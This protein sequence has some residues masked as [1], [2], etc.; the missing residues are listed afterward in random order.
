MNKIV[1]ILFSVCFSIV[2]FGATFTVTNTNDAGA[3]SL[4]QAILDANGSAGRD[5]IG[6]NFIGN[7]SIS[8]ISPLPSITESLFIDGFS[9]SNYQSN[10][11]TISYSGSSSS[12]YFVSCNGNTVRGLSFNGA[13]KAI[14]LILVNDSKIYQNKFT[15]NTN[16]VSIDAPCISNEIYANTFQNIT[17]SGVYI[18]AN[19]TKNLV[20][21]NKFTQNSNALQIVGGSIENIFQNNTIDNS[22]DHAVIISSGANKTRIQN[23]TIN[24]SIK[25]G[26]DIG[27][28][29]TNTAIL[30]NKISIAAT[31]VNIS[32]DCNGTYITGS[33]FDKCV[34]GVNLQNAKKDTLSQNT[35]LSNNKAIVLSNIDSSI[36]LNNLFD[37]NV[38][39]V[40]LQLVNNSTLTNN[41]FTN[42]DSTCILNTG[43]YTCNN[44][45]IN[46][47]Y[48]GLNSSST[49]FGNKS[50]GIRCSDASFKNSQIINNVICGNNGYGIYLEKNS[51]D[52]IIQKNKIGIDGAG[53]IHANKTGIYLKNVSAISIGDYDPQ[54]QNQI[55]G[56]TEYG[57]VMGTNAFARI[58]DNIISNNGIKGILNT[59]KKTPHIRSIK[60]TSTGYELIIQTQQSE[61]VVDLYQ[62]NQSGQ[63]TLTRINVPVVNS[64]PFKNVWKATL[65]LSTS[66]ANLA[67]ISSISTTSSEIGNYIDALVVTS[68]T[69][70]GEGTL[71]NA[72][73]YCNLLPDTNRVTFNIQG[74]GKHYLTRPLTS[75]SVDKNF[76]YLQGPII[77]DASMQ[78]GEVVVSPLSAGQM[79]GNLQ[80]FTSSNYY[81]EFNSLTL[82]D[83]SNSSVISNG[84][85]TKIRNMKFLNNY[86]VFSNSGKTTIENTY[87]EGNHFINNGVVDSLIVKNSVFKNSLETN[88]IQLSSSAYK[89]FENCLFDGNKTALSNL[90][91]TVVINSTFKNN[92]IGLTTSTNNLLIKN[93]FENNSIAGIQVINNLN[94][95]SQ[96]V[97]V[98]GNNPID[99]RLLSGAPGNTSKAAPTNLAVTPGYL[100][101]GKA[102]ANDS[103]E[104]FVSTPSLAQTATKYLGHTQADASGNWKFTII[105]IDASKTNGIVTT[106]TDAA[107]NTSQL[108]AQILVGPCTKIVTNTND[109]GAGSLRACIECAN[110][111]AGSDTIKFAISGA[112]PYRIKPITDL[113]PLGVAAD[114]VLLSGKT[115]ALS[116]AGSGSQEIIL[117]GSAPPFGTRLY[118][119]RAEVRDITITACRINIFNTKLMRCSLDSSSVTIGSP[120]N[121]FRIGILD[122]CTLYRN[123]GVNFNTDGGVGI[124]AKVTNSYIYNS[125]Y[126]FEGAFVGDSIIIENN[127]IGKDK[128][129]NILPVQAGIGVAVT[130]YSRIKNNII[131]TDATYRPAVKFQV[132]KCAEIINNTITRVGSQPSI[133]SLI[134]VNSAD[135]LYIRGNTI[136]NSYLNGI[137]VWV[138]GKTWIEN[139][140][141]TNCRVDGIGSN[142]GNNDS[143]YVRSN[144]TY[145]NGRNGIYIYATKKVSLTNNITGINGATPAPNGRSGIFIYATNI[146]SVSNNSIENNKTGLTLSAVHALSGKKAIV[147]QNSILKSDTAVF[148]TNGSGDLVIK[149]N[150]MDN[151]TAYGIY[152]MNGSSTSVFEKNTIS[153]SGIAGMYGI[154][155]ISNNKFIS[156]TFALN[157]NGIE[158]RDGSSNNMFIGNTFSSAIRNI[159]IYNGSSNNK[160]SQNTFITADTAIYLN[161]NIA[162]GNNNKDTATISSFVQT[163][164]YIELKGKGLDTDTI[165]VFS[166]NGSKEQA[167]AYLNHTKVAGTDWTLSIPVNA[168][169]NPLSNNYYLVTAT[170]LSNNTSQLSNVIKV[171]LKLSSSSLKVLPNQ[172]GICLGDSTLLDAVV[173]DVAYYKWY[174]KA[175]GAVVSTA[176]TPYF[177]KG[178]DYVLEVSDSFGNVA[179]DTINIIENQL[180]LAADFLMASETGIE[181][182][183]V[184]VDISYTK[185]DSLVWNWNGATATFNS[186]KYLLTFPKEGTYTIQLTSYLGLCAK[187]TQHSIDVKPGKLSPDIEVI[188]SSTI[189]NIK[190]GP[191]PVLAGIN[192][193]AELNY[194]EVVTTEVY[195]LLG[196]L[197]YTYKTPLPA[198]THTYEIDMSAFAS[199][200]YIVKVLSGVDQRVI[201]IVKQ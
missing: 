181:D 128:A 171:P 176:K 32:S 193:T 87:F 53:Q 61:D 57:I 94:K 158:L 168:G 115:Q 127:I 173:K 126:A 74:T 153:N 41:Y 104:I 6:F 37:K 142:S 144:I 105:G 117:D 78:K 161:R 121:P 43:S 174:N 154:G 29:I 56:N 40:S 13:N 60:Q 17:G 113:P 39:G 108:S 120:Y 186:D 138:N 148:I 180:P 146:D 135:S 123:S 26:I 63:A 145:S 4:R 201:K 118:T 170:D 47:N 191:N 155:G 122:S 141:V 52:V 110:A 12:L 185:P 80:Y 157:K 24:N 95:I 66:L 109:T 27:G 177:K 22:T 77:I 136:S 129:G 42:Q 28:G 190:A 10:P 130:H 172:A 45:K 70:I 188:Y 18:T 102:T 84:G 1:L 20:R 14:Q 62:G 167:T 194:D 21:D 15:G 133:Y 85:T 34:L 2:S 75:N 90:V 9:I 54:F 11:V 88:Q 140:T 189:I 111:N 184:V 58:Y 166:G 36:I 106:A 150:I 192:F 19:S 143:M 165:E 35:F 125:Q 79:S 98:S 72:V 196:A 156:N 3:G 198:K 96:N 67:V 99:L 89:R 51:Q 195:N 183:T 149:N 93:T 49:V 152:M 151:N 64:T 91:N 101:T 124:I 103:I 100:L 68:E 197:L 69:G 55:V 97:F 107:G 82:S 25:N 33:T 71:Y 169:F 76:I 132:V 114:D 175:T 5:S 162:P 73:E 134:E 48:I 65:P 38:I 7:R 50:D 16:G 44:I 164:A 59:A 178:G 199:G 147:N 31:A 159:K 187:S 182:Q 92:E 131:Y 179:S 200:S 23:N 160:L 83:F 119:Y 163:A 116:G 112:G 86:L 137:D 8:L 139:N 30:N 46:N 81:T